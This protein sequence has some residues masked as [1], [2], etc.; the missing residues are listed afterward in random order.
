M[1]HPI[2]SWVR[3]IAPKGHEN[4]PVGQVTAHE[5][6]TDFAGSREMYEVRFVDPNGTPD[7]EPMRFREQ[8]IEQVG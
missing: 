2:G 5:V 7:R 4:Y 8:E 6:Y 1:K 3:H